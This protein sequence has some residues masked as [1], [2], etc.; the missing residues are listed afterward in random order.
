MISFQVKERGVTSAFLFAVALAILILCQR[1]KTRMENLLLIAFCDGITG[2]SADAET[3]QKWEDLSKET[4]VRNDIYYYGSA[5][6]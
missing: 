2:I 4:P 1:C 5:H 3:A 6:L